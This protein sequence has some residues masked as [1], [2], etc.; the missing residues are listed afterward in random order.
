M[1][2]PQPE[3]V[4]IHVVQL[5]AEDDL[6]RRARGVMQLC[7]WLA[8]RRHIG[9]RAQHAHNRRDAAAHRDHDERHLG[10]DG[11]SAA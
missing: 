7:R 3:L 9:Q 1:A 6:L 5:V 8:A 2:L 10:A 11:W 4:W